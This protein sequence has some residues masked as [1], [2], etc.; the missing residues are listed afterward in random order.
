M[1]AIEALTK[2]YDSVAAVDDV[3][4][5]VEAGALTVI[6]GASGSGKSTLMRMVNRL[7]EPTSGRVLIDGEDAAALPVHELRRRIGYAI[8]NHGLF[9]H[10]TVAQNIATVPTLLGWDRRR[11]AARVEE[12]LHLFQL[13]PATFRSAIPMSS[14]AASSSASASRARW[15][16]S[17]NCC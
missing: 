6:V 10:R 9:P 12:L 4:M 8:Q 17:R 5:V 13:D 11:I 15:R 7:V 2:V 16:P 3:S 1:I 14:P